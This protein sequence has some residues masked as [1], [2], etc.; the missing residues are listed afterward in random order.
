MNVKIMSAS[1]KQNKLYLWYHGTTK[2]N[3]LSILEKGFVIGTCFTPQ[4]SSALSYGG[5]YVFGVLL[6]HDPENSYWE[7]ITPEV[8]PPERI[9]YLLHYRNVDLLYYNQKESLRW[10]YANEEDTCTVCDGRG[11]LNYPN[12]GHHLLPGGGKFSNRKIQVC[13]TCK[14]YGSLKRLK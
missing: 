4:L 12:D 14:G 1:K 6:T 5:P 2:E 11:E 8:I 10:R 9:Y 3:Y 7:W 13:P